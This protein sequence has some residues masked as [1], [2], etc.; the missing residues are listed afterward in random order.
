M[1]TILFSFN[2][3][4]MSFRSLEQFYDNPVSEDLLNITIV[5]TGKCNCKEAVSL[6]DQK[7][8]SS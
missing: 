1:S 8:G 4:L 5:V 7:G 2:M 6:H 3:N